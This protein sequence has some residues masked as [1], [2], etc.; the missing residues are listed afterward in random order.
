MSWVAVGVGV[1]GAALSMYG[2]QQNRKGAQKDIDAQSAQSQQGRDMVGNT[3]YGQNLW[4]AMSNP[5]QFNAPAAPT[6]EQFMTTRDGTPQGGQLNQQAYAAAM[7]K[8]QQQLATYQQGY[9]QSEQQRLGAINAATGGSVLDQYKDLTK[10]S[11]QGRAGI[12]GQYNAE[13]GRLAAGD[14]QAYNQAASYF[15]GARNAVDQLGAGEEAMAS[16]WGRGANALIDEQSAIDLKRANQSAMGM[17]AG[18]GLGGSS[19]NAMMQA[20]NGRAIGRDARH[21]K[22]GV[23]QGALDRTM[24]A[25][26]AR[27]GTMASMYGQAGTTLAS[28]RDASQG[29]AY[30]RAAGRTEQQYANLNTDLGYRQQIPN[31]MLELSQGSLNPGGQPYIPNPYGAGAGMVD[32]GAAAGG[33]SS[34]L[35]GAYLQ[36]QYAKGGSGS[37]QGVN[38]GLNNMGGSYDWQ[39]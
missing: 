32:L 31:T 28:L 4:G 39:Y 33:T 37:G 7:Q 20:A 16:Q 10:R 9:G 24:N 26:R 12:M 8:Y 19:M 21:Q 29:R 5:T 15:G 13:T 23:S 1:G 38:N 18:R 6:P 35:M 2:Q 25:R 3:F 17:M 36:N 27:T 30:G 14:T 11:G 34:M 22:L